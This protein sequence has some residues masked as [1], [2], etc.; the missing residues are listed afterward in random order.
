[1]TAKVVDRE[2]AAV[3]GA[4]AGPGGRIHIHS[5]DEEFPP[6]CRHC[7]STDMIKYGSQYWADRARAEPSRASNTSAGGAAGCLYTG[8]EWSVCAAAW[9]T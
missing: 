1:M 5:V 8:P 3:A 9:R 4:A 2:A 6:G 7:P